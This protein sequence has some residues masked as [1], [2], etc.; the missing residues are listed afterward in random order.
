MQKKKTVPRH[1][2][3]IN[4]RYYDPRRMTGVLYDKI[5]TIAAG[6]TIVNIIEGWVG[7]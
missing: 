1:K 5:L 7:A 2:V 4:S 3:S 6:N